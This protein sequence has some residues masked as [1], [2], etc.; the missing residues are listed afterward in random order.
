MQRAA[1]WGCQVPYLYE[2]DAIFP[3]S[4]SSCNSGLLGGVMAPHKRLPQHARECKDLK[5]RRR[6]LCVRRASGHQCLQQNFRE[7]LHAA[8]RLRIQQV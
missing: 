5:Q 3:P 2:R 8:Q 1:A 4:H 7:V 6:N